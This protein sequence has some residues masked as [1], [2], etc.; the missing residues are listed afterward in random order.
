MLTGKLCWLSGEKRDLL[1]LL[2]LLIEILELFYLYLSIVTCLFIC[3]MFLILA[4][5]RY[6]ERLHEAALSTVYMMHSILFCV[7]TVLMI[8]S[9][10]VSEFFISLGYGLA[11][12]ISILMCEWVATVMYDLQEKQLQRLRAKRANNTPD[13]IE[14]LTIDITF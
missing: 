13:F 9:A 1:K 14:K 7:S 4:G 8:H 3:I 6:S 5:I 10:W 2:N 11:S 12:C